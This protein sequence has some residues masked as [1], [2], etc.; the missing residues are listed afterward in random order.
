MTRWSLFLVVAGTMLFAHGQAP[1]KESIESIIERNYSAWVR[2]TY[3]KDSESW[4]SY[5]APNALFTPPIVPE[6]ETREAIL[7]YYRKAFADPNF[8]LDCRQV[9]VDVAQSGDMAWARGYCE[10][11]STTSKKYQC[12]KRFRHCIWSCPGGRSD[13]RQAN[14]S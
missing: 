11:T 3:A 12:V 2:A 9:S 6:L 14:I 8:V 7:N 5:L 4:C 1:A 10:A 13:D